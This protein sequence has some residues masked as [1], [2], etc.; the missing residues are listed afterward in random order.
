M[1]IVLVELRYLR[2]GLNLIIWILLSAC[3][4]VIYDLLSRVNYSIFGFGVLCCLRLCGAEELV[5]IIIKRE[6]CGAN[7]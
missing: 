4:A 6:E 1:F 2:F 7:N 5:N 3:I